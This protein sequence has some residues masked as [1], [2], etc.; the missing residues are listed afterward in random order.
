M[1]NKLFCDY[2]DEWIEVYKVGAVRDVTVQKYR[3]SSKWLRKLAP[4]LKCKEVTR[5][6]YQ[7]IINEYAKE[8]E[9]ITT[10]D[11]HRNLKAAVLDAV[12]EGYV[13]KDPT[14]RVIVKGKMPSKKR[15]KYLNQY[16]LH[17]V[18]KDLKLGKEPDMDWLILLVAKTG[19]RFSEALGLTPKDFD[20]EKQTLSVSKTWDYKGNGGFAPTKNKSSVRKIPIDFKTSI[21]FAAL[22]AG[23]DTDMPIFVKPG[24]KIYNSTANDRLFKHC[25]DTG[26]PEIAMHGLRH[27][28]ASLLLFQGVS[29]A[30]VSK[31]LGHANMTTTQNVYLHIMQELE[32]KDTDL[33]MRAMSTL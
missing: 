24:K 13:E 2:F 28:H 18:L 23:M 6:Q 22:I 12:D 10:R 7:K 5:Q 31:R 17:A 33:V 27:T 14:R 4:E 30:S 8:H 19:L 25:R 15:T 1:E 29:I 16:E 9:K 21:Q 26:V 3:M 32:S 20:F 11:F